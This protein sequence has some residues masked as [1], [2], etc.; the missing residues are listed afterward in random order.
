MINFKYIN[1]HNLAM[2][3]KAVILLLL[4]VPLVSAAPLKEEGFKL[5]SYMT[6]FAALITLP[7]FVSLYFH[8][9]K[10]N[11]GH[12]L[13]QPFLAMFIG[14]MGVLI[15]SLLDVYGV[16]TGATVDN[17][18]MVMSINRALSSLLIAGGCVVLFFTVKNKGLFSLSYYQHKRKGKQ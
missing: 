16:I 7:A 18:T 3:K 8:V 10:T 6:V 1:P 9:R 2:I 5:A 14:F 15:N 11:L 17:I 4:I 12:V 13:I